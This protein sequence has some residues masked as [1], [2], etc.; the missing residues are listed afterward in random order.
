MSMTEKSLEIWMSQLYFLGHAVRKG[1]H[2]IPRKIRW[3]AFKRK[4]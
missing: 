1:M 4:K 3:Q 2:L